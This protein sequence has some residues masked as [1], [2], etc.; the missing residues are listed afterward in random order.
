MQTYT[1]LL[2]GQQQYSLHF[3]SITTTSSI[4]ISYQQQLAT[5]QAC[6]QQLTTSSIGISAVAYYFINRHNSSSLSQLTTSSIGILY[7][8]QLTTSSIGILYPQQLTTSSIG[9]STVAYCFIKRHNSSSLLLHQQAYQQQLTTSSIGISAVAH[10]F[11]N[12]HIGSITNQ[13]TNQQPT[14]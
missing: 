1:L 5:S 4:G 10:Y 7:Q 12:R 14:N 2:Q 9:I 8:Q 11:I 13:P 6:Q 3:I